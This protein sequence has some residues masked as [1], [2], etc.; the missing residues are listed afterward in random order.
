[1]ICCTIVLLACAIVSLAR[2]SGLVSGHYQYE[3][4]YSPVCLNGVYPLT[5]G[6]MT[7]GCSIAVSMDAYGRIAG[8]LDL[9]TLQR[10]A[11]GSL[12]VQDNVPTL[13]LQTSGDDPSQTPSQIQGQWQG[14]S[15]V[16][17]ATTSNGTQPCTLDV[18]AAE[19]LIVTF[20][21]DL[22]VTQ[23]S[24]NG[25]GTATS[26]GNQIPVGVTGRNTPTQCSLRIIGVD[27]PQ[28]VWFG[29][30]TPTP[31]GFIASWNA[32][33]FG[34]SLSGIALE[35][36]APAESPTANNATNVSSNSF[37]ANWN[38]ATRAVGY[39]LDVSTINTF[40]NYLRGYQNRDVGDVIS[41][42]VKGL[43]P[44]TTYYYRVRAYNGGGSATDNSNVV[45]VITGV[46]PT[47]GPRPSATPK[48]SVPPPTPTPRPST[49]PKPR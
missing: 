31:T 37:V 27:L 32:S 3:V 45:T 34:A 6:E 25:S 28:F 35:I 46:P 49:T 36:F 47:P 41:F 39:R 21:V 48:P 24:V 44:N 18:S 5:V 43:N 9:R 33:G 16:G 19:P 12:F 1:V 8:T 2:A 40:A 11:T 7:T 20:D 14:N 4:F 15:F 42:G 10:P 38:T 22:V 29:V 30:G 26:C 17:T 13:Q 23:D